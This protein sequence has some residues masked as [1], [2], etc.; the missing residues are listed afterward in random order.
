MKT[1]NDTIVCFVLLM[2]K[3]TAIRSNSVDVS[4]VL[5]LARRLATCRSFMGL[6][7]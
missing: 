6:N 5:P 4:V 7:K 3:Q 2:S 1:E